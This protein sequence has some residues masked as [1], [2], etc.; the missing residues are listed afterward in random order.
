MPCPPVTAFI[1]LTLA[2]CLALALR[3]GDAIDILGFHMRT[4]FV[5]NGLTRCQWGPRFS[6]LE[7]VFFIDIFNGGIGIRSLESAYCSLSYAEYQPSMFQSKSP[8]ELQRDLNGG[9][10]ATDP[11]MSEEYHNLFTRDEFR[12]TLTG[13]DPIN[14]LTT[15]QEEFYMTGL[16]FENGL[17]RC[18]WRNPFYDLEFAFYIDTFN[19]GVGLNTFKYDALPSSRLNYYNYIPPMFSNKVPA[20]LDVESPE[21]HQASDPFMHNDYHNLFTNDELHGLNP[22]DM[23]KVALNGLRTRMDAH[24]KTNLDFLNTIHRATLS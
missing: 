18:Y 7:L 2:P 10:Q 9:H 24:E 12:G 23:C 19:K 20:S 22:R 4:F 13:R 17:T 3:G 5:P 8:A 6:N 14:S 21:G 1:L 11:F 16:S 15:T